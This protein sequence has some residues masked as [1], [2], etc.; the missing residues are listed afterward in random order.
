[1]T[2]PNEAQGK[3]RMERPLTVSNEAMNWYSYAN[4]LEQRLAEE[5]EFKEI[6][7][8]VALKK[9][10]ERNALA[11]KLA[12]LGKCPE[13]NGEYTETCPVCQ[14]DSH[15]VVIKLDEKL[16]Q[17]MRETQALALQVAGFRKVLERAE[18]V[19]GF[20]ASM[21]FENGDVMSAEAQLSVA[22][23][24][25]LEIQDALSRLQSPTSAEKRVKAMEKVVAMVNYCLSNTDPN[26]A[27]KVLLQQSMTDFDALTSDGK[28][29]E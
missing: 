20:L 18:K 28:E 8:D 24:L 6:N 21:H 25:Q 1:M 9:I 5:R 7:A 26:L 11:E 3:K 13:C 2:T 17:A 19:S 15:P 12:A 16:G 10:D 4:H 22:N 23:A 29:K 14:L 27:T